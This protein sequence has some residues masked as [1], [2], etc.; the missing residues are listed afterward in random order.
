MERNNKKA[1]AKEHTGFSVNSPYL[2]QGLWF[3]IK[4]S[5][6]MRY[7]SRVFCIKRGPECVFM[8]GPRLELRVATCTQVGTVSFALAG[9]AVLSILQKHKHSA[10]E[11][12]ARK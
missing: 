2:E 6:E 11:W 3:E 7:K 12:A 9:E 10:D 4:E 5:K 8:W 1:G